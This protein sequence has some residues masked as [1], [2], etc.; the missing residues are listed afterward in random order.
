MRNGEPAVAFCAL[1]AATLCLFS[2]LEWEILGCLKQRV[3]L[4]RR[5]EHGVTSGVS[6][7]EWV[8]MP[9]GGGWLAEMTGRGL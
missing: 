4:T 9:G 6:G 1:W 8:G 5:G 3:R 7:V 2:Q